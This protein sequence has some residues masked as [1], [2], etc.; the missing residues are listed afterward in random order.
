MTYKG[1]A[2]GKIIELEEALPYSEGQPVSVAV[3][4]LRPEVQPGSP[5]AIL[6]I[7]RNL[8]DLNPGDVDE[9]EQ[10]IKRGR[11]PVH[12]QGVFGGEGAEN[13]R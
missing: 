5:V 3:E 7:V 6:K 4:P 1:T 12:S 11:L 8:P 9:L 2:R 10:A 13:R